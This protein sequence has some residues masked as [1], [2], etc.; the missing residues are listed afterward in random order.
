MKD[1]IRPSSV[2]LLWATISPAL[3]TI[4]LQREGERKGR[5]GSR[6]WKKQFKLIICMFILT[7]FLLSPSLS[8]NIIRQN[9]VQMISNSQ[10]SSVSKFCLLYEIVCFDPA[11]STAAVASSSTRISWSYGEEHELNKPTNTERERER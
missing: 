8:P 3:S 5:E 10:D 9:G 11:I 7:I 4:T 2:S 6:K 1:W